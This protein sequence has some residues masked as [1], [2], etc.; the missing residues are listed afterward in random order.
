MSQRVGMASDTGAQSREFGLRQL[1]IL[2]YLKRALVRVLK[3]L[4]H[5][6]QFLAQ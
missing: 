6:R 1:G 3:Y 5:G 4:R 2:G